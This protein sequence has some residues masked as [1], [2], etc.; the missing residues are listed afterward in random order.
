VV[1]AT[2]LLGWRAIAQFVLRRRAGRA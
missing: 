1:L 2:F